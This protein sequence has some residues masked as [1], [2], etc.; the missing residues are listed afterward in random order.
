M[1]RANQAKNGDTVTVHYTV[2]ACDA[3]SSGKGTVLQSTRQRQ[4]FR[5]VVG[6]EGLIGG[7]DQA[8]IGMREG[9]S[10][11][12]RVPPERAYGI[13]RADL[14]WTIDRADYPPGVDP[15]VGQRLELPRKNSTHPV[16]VRV[17]AVDDLTVTVDANHALAGEHL[18]FDVMML[19]I[20]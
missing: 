2:T 12:F 13:R 10:K 18:T 1:V 4:P 9:E 7:F 8:I 19:E 6:Q 5:F 20:A 11:T 17:T 14:V 3:R 15:V 16:K